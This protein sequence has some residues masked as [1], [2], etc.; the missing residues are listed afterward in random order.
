MEQATNPFSESVI[1]SYGIFSVGLDDDQVVLEF[2]VYSKP[3]QVEN[4]TLKD[5]NMRSILL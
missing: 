2:H 4:N 1:P 5:I 3:K